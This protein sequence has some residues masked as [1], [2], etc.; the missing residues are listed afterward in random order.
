MYRNFVAIDGVIKDQ[1]IRQLEK[2]SQNKTF[3]LAKRFTVSIF[4]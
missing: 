4:S 2:Q 3:L 1:L